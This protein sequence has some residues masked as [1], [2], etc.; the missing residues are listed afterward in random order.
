MIDIIYIY[1]YIY[2]I[3]YPEMQVIGVWCWMFIAVKCTNPS[4]MPK[5]DVSWVALGFWSAESVRSGQESQLEISSIEKHRPFM[6]IIWI[7]CDMAKPMLGGSWSFMLWGVPPM[8][9]EH[10]LGGSSIF[11]GKIQ[12]SLKMDSAWRLRSPGRHIYKEGVAVHGQHPVLLCSCN[13]WP[14]SE[15]EHE[16]TEIKWINQQL[17]SEDGSKLCTQTSWFSRPWRIFQNWS[18]AHRHN[19]TRG[20]RANPGHP[21]TIPDPWEHHSA[22]HSW[23]ICLPLILSHTQI[24]YNWY[25]KILIKL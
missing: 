14:K 7:I 11:V 22:I 21:R 20:T 3:C 6:M 9:W 19:C 23:M 18:L 24:L 8:I 17:S 16:S 13:R 1:I 12:R 4:R 5:L 25:N 15:D 10:L 2:I